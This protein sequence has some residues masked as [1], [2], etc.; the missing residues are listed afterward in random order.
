MT[1]F[2]KYGLERENGIPVRLVD[3]DQK[4]LPFLNSQSVAA[5]N[6][7]GITFVPTKPEAAWE[8]AIPVKASQ[9]PEWFFPRDAS[10]FTVGTDDEQTFECR[11]V[12]QGVRSGQHSGLH[13]TRR[14]PQAEQYFRK[15]LKVAPDAPVTPADFSRYGAFSFLLFRL[16]ET[17]YFLDFSPDVGSDRGL[18]LFPPRREILAE[19]R[20]PQYASQRAQKEARQRGL[21]YYPSRLEMSEPLPDLPYNLGEMVVIRQRETS[22]GKSF[23]V[24]LERTQK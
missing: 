1:T 12:G 22:Q 9:V 8:V 15:R 11:F 23:Q 19:T 3:E 5:P 7:H 2:A 16:D 20:S 14:I 18:G 21:P 24:A 17:V 13:F 6:D 10:R 4:P